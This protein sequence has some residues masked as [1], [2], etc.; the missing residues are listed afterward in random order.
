MMTKVCCHVAQL[1]WNRSLSLIGVGFAPGISLNIA[2][3]PP[4]TDCLPRPPP[5]PLHHLLQNPISSSPAPG[6]LTYNLTTGA[7]RSGRSISVRTRHHN[8][9]VVGV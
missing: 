4:K 7:A 5:I 3:H 6:S 2:P 8:R 1:Q 9:C